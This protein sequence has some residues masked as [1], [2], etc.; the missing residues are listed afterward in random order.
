MFADQKFAS[1]WHFV[2]PVWQT[3]FSA[4][5]NKKWNELVFDFL[6]TDL[7]WCYYTIASSTRSP[8]HGSD[9]AAPSTDRSAAAHDELEGNATNLLSASP[10]YY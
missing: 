7:C 6:E 4:D 3:I 8:R 9:G 1:Q 10:L 2:A 5:L